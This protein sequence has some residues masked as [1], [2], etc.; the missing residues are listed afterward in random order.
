MVL[1]EFER[2]TQWCDE[3]LWVINQMMPSVGGTDP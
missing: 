3:Q 1:A 2:P